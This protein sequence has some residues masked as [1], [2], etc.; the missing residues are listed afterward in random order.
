MKNEISTINMNL[1]KLRKINKMSQEE[2]GEQ[3]GVSRQAVAKWESGETVP[4]IQNCMALAK[5]YEVSIDDLLHY[6]EKKNYDVGI[7]PKGKY[8]FGT[9]TMGERGQIVI[10]KKARNVFD[11]KPGDELIILGDEQQGIGI[12]KA[13]V[14]LAFMRE[15]RNFPKEEEG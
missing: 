15:V 8:L 11:I 1:K 5:L 9:V 10:P 13:D 2:V 14:M 12:M 4:D 7:P 3:I 6:E